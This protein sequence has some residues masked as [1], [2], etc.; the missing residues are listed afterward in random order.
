M[1]KECIKWCDWFQFFSKNHT[2]LYATTCSL[3]QFDEK[4]NH[5]KISKFWK[6]KKFKLQKKWF[7]Y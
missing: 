1:K 7:F 4:I 6:K 2:F 3:S 5:M